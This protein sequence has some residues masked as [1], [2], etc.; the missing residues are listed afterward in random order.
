MWQW[1][2]QG[3]LLF[4]MLPLYVI[5]KHHIMETWLINNAWNFSYSI[6]FFVAPR[7]ENELFLVDEQ[8]KSRKIRLREK[9][10]LSTDIISFMV[11]KNSSPIIV[12]MFLT[13]QQQ[14]KK[15]NKVFTSVVLFLWGMNFPDAY[16]NINIVKIDLAK[17]TFF[18]LCWIL[19][20]P[21]SD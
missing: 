20:H 5:K 2:T 10:F 7:G 1:S 21:G 16:V 11:H 12:F 13:T 19:F 17:K 6:S 8:G 3:N 18:A 9:S 4:P 14:R 15:K